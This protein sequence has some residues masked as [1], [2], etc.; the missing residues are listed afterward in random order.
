[1]TII[2]PKSD[3]IIQIFKEINQA[4]NIV[5]NVISYQNIRKFLTLNFSFIINRIFSSIHK[6][7]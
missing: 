7:L 6:I 4:M 1:M 2:I 3:N 5:L